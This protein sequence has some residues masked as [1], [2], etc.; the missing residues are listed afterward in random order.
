MCAG[1]GVCV[2]VRSVH[3]CRC[4]LVYVCVQVSVCVLVRVHMYAGICMD[5]RMQVSKCVCVQ[6]HVCGSQRSAFSVTPQA[7]SILSCVLRQ[8]LSSSPA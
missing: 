3:M 5:I 1:A 6:V 8:S 4:I 2:C 7:P